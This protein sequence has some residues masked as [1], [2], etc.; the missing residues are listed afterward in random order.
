MKYQPTDKVLI[1][2]SLH[3]HEFEIGAKC[4]IAAIESED[5]FLIEGKCKGKT[6]TW[7]L[8][9]EEFCPVF[10]IYGNK[11][12][13]NWSLRATIGGEQHGF[14]MLG[15]TKERATA[16]AIRVFSGIANQ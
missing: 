8:G 9:K 13:T 11:A 15:S 5:F 1:V 12:K 16:E 6:Q 7:A 3:G 4:T 2:A 10:R 14:G